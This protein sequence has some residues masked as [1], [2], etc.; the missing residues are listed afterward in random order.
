M[1]VVKSAKKKEERIL[2]KIIQIK[3]MLLQLV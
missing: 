2:K 3:K 1:M